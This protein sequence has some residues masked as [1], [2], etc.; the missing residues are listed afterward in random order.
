[1]IKHS[2]RRST[3][4]SSE[5]VDNSRRNAAQVTPMHRSS[6]KSG[7]STMGGFWAGA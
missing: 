1:M 4:S 2:D 5:Q 7:R 6:A 3:I